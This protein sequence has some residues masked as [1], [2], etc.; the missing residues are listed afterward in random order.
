MRL[1]DVYK[2]QENV[3]AAEGD[4]EYRT[5][6]EE[7]VEDLPPADEAEVETLEDSPAEA[8]EQDAQSTEEPLLEEIET[9]SAITDE[10]A[11]KE[12]GA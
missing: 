11:A 3:R 6:A 5:E 4:T 10:Q 9:E 8:L 7:A 12:G 2:R 1:A